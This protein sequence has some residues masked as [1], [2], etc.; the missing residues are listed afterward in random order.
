MSTAITRVQTQDRTIN[1]LQNNI[2]NSVNPILGNAITNGTIL[3]GI[4]LTSG[5][6]TINHTLGRNLQGWIVIRQ[7]ASA[8]IYDLQDTNPRPSLT[9]ILHSSGSVV[10]DLYVF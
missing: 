2:I 9:L 3:S 1:Q 8:T 4:K 10:V 6:N 7:R 5:S